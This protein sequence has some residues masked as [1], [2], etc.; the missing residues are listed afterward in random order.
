[1][2]PKTLFRVLL[3]FSLLGVVAGALAAA[4]PGNISE[5]WRTA[6]EWNGNGGLYEH[7]AT[8]ELPTHAVARAAVIGGLVVFLLAL[9][10]VY[11]GL[12]LFWRF[13]RLAN[14]LLTILFVFAAPWAGLVVLLPLEAAFYDF[15]MLCEG[16]VLALS[17]TPPIKGYFESDDL[18]LGSSRVATRVP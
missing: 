11:V 18:T 13:A 17:Y 5:E 9:L 10:S 12:F 16:V 3:A 1:M 4:F 7:L 8:Y 15:T 6:T 14:L 2:S